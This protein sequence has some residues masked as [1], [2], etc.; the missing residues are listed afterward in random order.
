MDCKVSV[1]TVVY[2]DVLHIR[3]TMESFFAQ[4]W[5][6]KEYIVV[7]GGS[8]DGTVEVIREY[9]DRLAWWCSEPDGGIYE[10]MN[11]GVMHA[12][13]DWI[14]ILNSGDV[15]A[16]P[17]S[18]EKVFVT[19]V[20]DNDDV[21][22]LYGDSIC[23]SDGNGDVFIPSNPDLTVMEHEPA[24]RHGSS[25]VRTV[26][27]RQ[28][29]YCTDKKDRY[30]F[31]LDWLQIHSLYKEAYKFRQVNAIVEVFREEGVSNNEYQSRIYNLMICSGRNP[32]WLDKKKLRIKLFLDRVRSSVVAKWCRALLFECV[33]NDIL[34]HI[35]F[36]CLRQ[37]VLKKMRMRIGKGSFVMKS[38]YILSP[39]KVSIGNHSHINRNCVLDGRGGLTIGNNVS[40]SFNV[41]LMT[42]G[43]DVRSEN[44]RGR[45][46]PIVID[47]NVWIG[48]GATVL[49][50][51]TIGKG[52][53]VCAGAVVVSDVEPYAIVGGIPARKIGER[54]SNLNYTCNGYS[55]FT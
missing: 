14:N 45:F 22:V 23:R 31:A 15:F 11:K 36:W 33:V 48:V 5:A 12:T 44:F 27:Q 6:N 21:D 24:Y 46:L 47:D 19:L 42:G 32:S 10:A 16:F 54:P 25:F 50:N 43:H 53:V 20:D 13:G 49:Q 30:G 17:E 35:P 26:V 1:I 55:P 52:A 40:V 8:T 2:N 37:S 4:T 28:H 51:V 38:N 3:E 41:S 34:P 39:S 9:A 18:L 7:D 29:P